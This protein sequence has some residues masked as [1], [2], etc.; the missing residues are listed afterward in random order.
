M[1][2]PLYASVIGSYALLGRRSVILQNHVWRHAQHLSPVLAQKLPDL[3]SRCLE[4]GSGLR[5]FLS[6]T[7]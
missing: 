3:G 7:V 5:L 2:L 6:S 1:L 4:E